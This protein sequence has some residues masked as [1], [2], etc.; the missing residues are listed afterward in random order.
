MLCGVLMY[1]QESGVTDLTGPQDVS[2]GNFLLPKGF[3]CEKRLPFP[4]AA[5]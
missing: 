3:G 4:E 1:S 2:P 5:L